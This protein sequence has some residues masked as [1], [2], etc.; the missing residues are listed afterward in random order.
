MSVVSTGILM[1]DE[2]TG[3]AGFP[4]GALVHLYGEPGAGKTSVALHVVAE[5]QACGGK[6]VW[7]DADHALDLRMAEQRGVDTSELDIIRPENGEAALAQVASS[8]RALEPTVLVIDSVAQLLPPEPA[9]NSQDPVELLIR[10]GL[11]Q[12]VPLVAKANAVLLCTN[13][14]Y[15]REGVMFGSSECTFGGE[16]LHY[17]ASLDIRIR[18]LGLIKHGDSS[19]GHR[20]RAQLRKSRVGPSGRDADFDLLFDGGINRGSDAF[21]VGQ[22]L[23]LVEFDGRQYQVEGI[24]LGEQRNDVVRTL[25]QSA[26]L[27]DTLVDKLRGLLQ[28]RHPPPEGRS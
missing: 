24:A 14:T 11:R 25:N 19:I 9:S 22:R 23:G 10:S 5:A 28:E 7:V 3:V 20:V 21:E 1:L 27:L 26:E 2:L 4:R 17:L 12:L 18:K 8:L 13:Q 6:A 15:P 16:T